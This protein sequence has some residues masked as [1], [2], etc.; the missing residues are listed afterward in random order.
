VR[1]PTHSDSEEFAAAPESRL[2]ALTP[3]THPGEL[4]ADNSFRPD[5]I[6][7]LA[8]HAVFRAVGGDN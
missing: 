3:D 7:I 6:G 5:V 2:Q 8:S 1:Y 4:D